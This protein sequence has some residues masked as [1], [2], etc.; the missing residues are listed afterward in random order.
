MTKAAQS[1]PNGRGSKA[2]RKKHK[3]ITSD[4]GN[5][6]LPGRAPSKAFY[7]ALNAVAQMRGKKKDK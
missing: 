3:D 6:P 1:P 7:A 4:G 5:S 2:Q